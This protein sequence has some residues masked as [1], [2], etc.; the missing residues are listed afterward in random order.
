MQLEIRLRI[1]IQL[2]EASIRMQDVKSQCTAHCIVIVVHNPRIFQEKLRRLFIT[3]RNCMENKTREYNTRCSY[4]VFR[5]YMIQE[6]N[7]VRS[8]REGG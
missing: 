5:I 2:H 3:L 4:G 8:K 1:T 6:Q 7:I